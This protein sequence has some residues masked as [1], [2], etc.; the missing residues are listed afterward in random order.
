MQKRDYE[1]GNCQRC[2]AYTSRL[3]EMSVNFYT[4]H[5]MKQLLYFDDRVTHLN[6]KLSEK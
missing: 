3:Q 5:F 4:K 2:P 1:N 6:T